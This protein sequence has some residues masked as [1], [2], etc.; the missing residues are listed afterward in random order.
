MYICQAVLLLNDY[1]YFSFYWWIRLYISLTILLRNNFTFSPLVD[2]DVPVLRCPAL[3][4]IHLLFFSFTGRSLLPV[5]HRTAAHSCMCWT[6][7]QIEISILWN[8]QTFT[9]FG[10]L[11]AQLRPVAGSLSTI[12]LLIMSVLYICVMPFQKHS[13]KISHFVFLI[14]SC[15]TSSWS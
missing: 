7:I 15:S 12:S 1:T 6:G 13:I 9:F 2:Q 5:T 14:V 3:H 4:F 11:F 10:P 8:F